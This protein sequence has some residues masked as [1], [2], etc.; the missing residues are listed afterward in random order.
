MPTV[1]RYTVREL[2]A[3]AEGYRWRER[4]AWERA[5]WQT[6]YLLRAWIPNAPTPQQ[7]LGEAD[8]GDAEQALEALT[9]ATLSP[10]EQ[11][12]RAFARQ[13]AGAH[14]AR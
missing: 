11:L 6:S 1:W 4:Q 2:V 8:P 3:A 10:V 13:K 14:G 7:L 12:D 9:G 5:A